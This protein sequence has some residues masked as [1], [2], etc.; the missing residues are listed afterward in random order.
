MP[1]RAPSR[2]ERLAATPAEWLRCCRE[3][4]WEPDERLVVE[5]L[6]ALRSAFGTR[7]GARRA[8]PYVEAQLRR[9]AA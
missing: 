7:G 3:R 4:G 8:R 1:A 2:G 9:L 6:H 5:R